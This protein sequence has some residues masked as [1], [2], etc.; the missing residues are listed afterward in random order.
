[1]P[2]IGKSLILIGAVLIAAGVVLTFGARIPFF[3]LGRLPGDIVYRRGNFT[4]YFP[5]ITSIA[6][7][8]VLTLLFW[9]FGRK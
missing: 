1:L 9:I 5:I 4:F 2:E 7:S 8:L 3:R 6:V